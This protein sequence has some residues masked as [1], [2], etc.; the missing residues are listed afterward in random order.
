MCTDHLQKAPNPIP[1]MSNNRLEM[2][3]EMLEKN[4]D[5]TFLNYAAALEHR[6][7]NHTAKAIRIFKKIID[8]DPDY[9]ATYYQLGKLLEEKG[10]AS[11][12]LEVYKKGHALA[13]IK[14]DIKAMGELSEAMMI[15]DTGDD[16]SW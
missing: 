14:K 7:E 10:K 15:L 9:L 12:A 4:P 11:E 5:D 13:V 1:T 8:Q 3:A 6:K 16:E 2:I